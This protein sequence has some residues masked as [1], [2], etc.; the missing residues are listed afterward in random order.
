MM[1]NAR[2]ASNAARAR[3]LIDMGSYS[4][5]ALFR[6]GVALCEQLAIGRELEIAG[7]QGFSGSTR[8]VRRNTHPKWPSSER[9]RASGRVLQLIEIQLRFSSS[10]LAEI[11]DFDSPHPR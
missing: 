1:G 3:R 7:S 8:T 4:C 11:S 10:G 5:W 2:L 9:C 6:L